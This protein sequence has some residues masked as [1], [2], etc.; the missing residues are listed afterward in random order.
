MGSSDNL[1]AVLKCAKTIAL[2]DTPVPQP[3]PGQVQMR[4]HSVGICGSDVHYWQHM[5]IG[6]TYVVPEPMIL[7]HESSG[8]VTKLGE[9]VTN[10]SVG[11]KVAIEP[12]VPCAHC[13]FCKAGT[14]NLCPDVAFLATPPIHGSLRRFHCHAASFCYKLPDSVSLEEGALLEPLAVAVHACRRAHITAGDRVLVCGA[15]PIG[16]VNAMVASASGATDI[17]CTDI[18]DK[19]LEMAKQCGATHVINVRGLT[20]EG[21]VEQ[22]RIMLGGHKADKAIE[23]SG[24]QPSVKLAIHSVKA[25]GTVVLVGMG[26]YDEIKIPVMTMSTREIDIRGIF[27]YANCYPAALELVKSGKVDI[28]KLVT[29]RF[30]I[31]KTV[32][33]FE[34]TLRGEGIKIVIN[35]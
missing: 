25:S 14:Y 31:E 4:M 27:R 22:I 16:L 30:P 9:G 29:H 15:G 20:N 8:T 1:S 11:D 34:T 26:P 21:A 35:C 5:R 23:C 10:L 18:D 6:D 33:A 28:K 17:V 3:L 32:E 13:S 24:A 7:G 2:E 12:G 19:R